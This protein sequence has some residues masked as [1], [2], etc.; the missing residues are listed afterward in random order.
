MQAEEALPEGWKIVDADFENFSAGDH[1]LDV[2]V[3]SPRGPEGSGGRGGTHTGR[4][5]P[6]ARKQGARR[7]GG[8]RRL[9]SALA[10]VEGKRQL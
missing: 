2:W 8:E 9:G 6:A 5:V 1:W 3:P 10:G 4:G 7:S